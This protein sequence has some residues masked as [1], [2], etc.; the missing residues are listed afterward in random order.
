M[1]QVLRT[2]P[3]IA[4]LNTDGERHPLEN[5]LALITFTLGMVSIILG[6]FV[7]D[8]HLVAALAGVIGFPLA[9]YSQMISA[10]TG[11]RWFNVIG[12]IGAFV[13]TG[14]ALAGGGFSF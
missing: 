12:M 11:E 14:L 4:I 10:T 5:S 7:R 9:L 1:P 6:L 3:N 8:A 2:R 13:G